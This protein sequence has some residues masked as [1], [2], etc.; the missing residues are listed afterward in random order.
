MKFFI[1]FCVLIC[2]FAFV[3]SSPLSKI[4]GDKDVDIREIREEIGKILKA[5]EIEIPE[6]FK[7]PPVV[8]T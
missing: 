3:Q 4:G 2:A 6:D 5:L 8:K 7:L 1:A